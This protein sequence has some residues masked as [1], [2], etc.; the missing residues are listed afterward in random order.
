[1]VKKNVDFSDVG[2]DTEQLTHVDNED[3]MPLPKMPEE[4]AWTPLK[5]RWVPITISFLSLAACAG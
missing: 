1:M 3:L 5:E 4:E 2:K